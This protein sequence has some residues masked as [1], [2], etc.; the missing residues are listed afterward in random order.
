MDIVYFVAATRP[1]ILFPIEKAAQ[2]TDIQAEKNWNEA[3]RVFRYLQSTSNYGLSILEVFGELKVFNDA[4]FAGD[5][6]TRRFTMGVIAV[7]ADCAVSC[8]I[9]LQKATILSKTEAEV[10]ASKE[11]AKEFGWLKW[12]LS[13]FTKKNTDTIYRQRQCIKLTKEPAVSQKVETH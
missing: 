4:D 9:W 8:I 11:G 12:L 7:F 13:D 3:T 5:K 6:V 2:V 1:N 10:I